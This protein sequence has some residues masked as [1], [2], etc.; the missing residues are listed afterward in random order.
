MSEIEDTIKDLAQKPKSVETDGGTVVEVGVQSAIAADE[1]LAKK[2]ASEATGSAA[3]K[4]MGF[5]MGVLRG[6][7][8]F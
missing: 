8:H 5:R 6:P 4:R 7:G 3:P 2:T 1:Y